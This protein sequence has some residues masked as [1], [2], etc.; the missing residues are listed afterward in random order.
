MKPSAILLASK[1]AAVAA[2]LLLV[3]RGWDV[4]EVVAGDEPIWLPGPSVRE[5]A[6]RLG[7]K[8][9][10]SQSELSTSGHDFVVSY[11]FRSRVNEETRSRGRYALNFHAA[12]LPQF[13][14]WAFY[15]AAI[16]EQSEEYGCTC[17]IMDEYFDTGPLVKVRRF[18]IDASRETAISLE[19]RAQLEMLFL[20]EEII[21]TYRVRGTLPSWPQDS[22][23]IRYLNAEQFKLLKA[24]PSDASEELADRIAR[25]F[26]YPPYELAYCTLPSGARVEVIPQVVKLDVARHMHANDLSRALDSLGLH[27]L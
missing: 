5:V 18:A 10:S 17:H 6:H 11:M 2:L 4:Q 13:G 12:P 27:L 9:V 7:I 3:Q 16:L 25:A 14:G 19:R 26:W 8:W 20:L 24:I 15:N 23:K 1:P 21:A 22:V